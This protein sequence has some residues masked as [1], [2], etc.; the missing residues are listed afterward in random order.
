MAQLKHRTPWAYLAGNTPLHRCPAG[1]K[2]I[3]LLLF[4]AASVWGLPG[5]AGAAALILAG[6]FSAG[7]SPRALFAGSRPLV[8]MLLVFTAFRALSA[9]SGIPSVDAGVFSMNAET[10]SVNIEML[11]GSFTLRVDLPALQSGLFL[12]A[13]ILVCFAAASLFFAV[14]TTTEIRHSL[15]RAESFLTR[16]FSGKKRPHNAA[17][18]QGRL[19]LSLALMLGFLPRFFE[20]WENAR[21]AA[22][23]RG[24]KSDV[25][26]IMAILP[27]VTERMIEAAAETAEA[28]ES[29]GLVV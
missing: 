1:I 6:A 24:S 11:F 19:S 15:A 4:S 10:L 27:L 18:K 16:P 28:L 29:R 9:G 22:L 26:M 20:Y 21:L 3:L 23:A 12:S 8:I 7:L 25:R 13:G 17:Q 5:A 2:L 14:T